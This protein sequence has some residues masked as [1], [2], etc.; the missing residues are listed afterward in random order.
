[1][2]KFVRHRLTPL[3]V[4]A[5]FRRHPC[6]LVVNVEQVGISPVFVHAAPGIL[7]VVEDLT[8]KHMPADAPD[9]LELV[10]LLQVFMAEHNVIK[11]LNLERDVIESDL[12]PLD[13]EKCMVIDVGFATVA[14]TQRGMGLDRLA[15][16]MN[17]EYMATG[18]NQP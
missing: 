18:P 11:I 5:L 14:A 15:K 6:R 2:R 10:Y 9:V 7:P 13:A 16:W 1:M 3:R 4:Q 8:A 17:L 12:W